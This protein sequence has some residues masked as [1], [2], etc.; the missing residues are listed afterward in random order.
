MHAVKLSVDAF[1]KEEVMLLKVV[2][3]L[4]LI[5]VATML[6]SLVA[7]F[8]EAPC[9]KKWDALL[10]EQEIDKPPTATEVRLP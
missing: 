8:G 4:C 5:G 1:S 7:T 2:L 6:S 10:R 9:A 3:I